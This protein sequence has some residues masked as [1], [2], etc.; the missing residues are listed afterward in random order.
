MHDIA[1]IGGGM[2]GAAVAYGL[3]DAGAKVVVLDEGDV[4]FR[5]ARGNAG[6]LWV[7]GKGDG[8]PAYADWTRLSADHWPDFAAAL[9]ELS[10][11]DIHFR[12][13]GGLD[14][15]LG[16][17]ELEA[18]A[19]QIAR[20]KRQQ[21][22]RRYLA[23]VVDAPSLRRMIPQ[24]G[25]EVSGG[26][27]SPH[28]GEVNP[29]RL[30]RALHR[31]LQ[32]RD[33]QYVP[34]QLVTGIARDGEGYALTTADRVWRA[35][36]VV[37]AAG[38]GTG[39]LAALAGLRVPVLP[40]RGHLMVTERLAPFLQRPSGV[41]RQTREGTL[42]IGE[43]NEMVGHDNHTQVPVLA[44]LA[45]RAARFFP[46]LRD[47]QIIRSWACLRVLT[48]DGL[49]VYT[50]SRSH[51]GV[52]AL[53]THS[54]VTLAAAHATALAGAI[55]DGALDGLTGAFPAERFDMEQGDVPATA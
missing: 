9:Q 34:G 4:A 31:G 32:R 35:G 10:G 44:H 3:A 1:V 2:I 17:D 16:A 42:L 52:F 48:P 27:Y 29:L 40:E 11:L 33:G 46:F 23:E 6:L 37:I 28:D 5:A 24:L 15:C 19:A 51:P 30:L 7:Q 18:Q 20:M 41:F 55:L 47:V 26:T 8:H 36:R 21:A 45:A 43:S 25:D 54:A 12:Q 38:L 50:Q 39:K 22:G 53:T 49:P 14:F 13:D